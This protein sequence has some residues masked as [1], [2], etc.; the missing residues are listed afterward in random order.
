[1]FETENAG[2]YKNRNKN[3]NRLAFNMTKGTRIRREMCS[4][5]VGFAPNA[6]AALYMKYSVYIVPCDAALFMSLTVW[7]K[8]HMTSPHLG[9]VGG[10]KPHMMR[11][12]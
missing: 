2:N 12:W 1:M 10:Y 8:P 7:I 4:C 9:K 11:D 6:N 5:C 3:G